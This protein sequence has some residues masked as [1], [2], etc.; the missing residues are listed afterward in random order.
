MR[1]CHVRLH[2]DRYLLS[3]LCVRIYGCT[4]CHLCLSIYACW[5]NNTWGYLESAVLI[6]LSPLCHKSSTLSF[7][8]LL[9]LWQ[10]EWTC[11]ILNVL[12]DKT[13]Y[14]FGHFQKRTKKSWKYSSYNSQQ[15]SETLKHYV[16]LPSLTIQQSDTWNLLFKGAPQHSFRE[17]IC[18]IWAGL[19]HDIRLLHI[20]TFHT[21]ESQFCWASWKKST[22]N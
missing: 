13:L 7:Y 6:N 8:R 19:Y 16:S 12:T 3:R 17:K 1:I 4:F 18:I 2:A 21:K 9:I 15:T 11:N 14:L 22:V 5:E 10:A 20:I